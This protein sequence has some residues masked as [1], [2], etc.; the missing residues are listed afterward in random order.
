MNKRELIKHIEDLPYNEGLI[1]DTIKISR[2][3]LLKLIEQLDEP[4]KVKIPQVIA[5]YIKQKKDD[6]Y[7]LLGAMI[8]IRS[9]KN[10]EIDEWFE[11]DDN[12]E[13]FARAWLDGYELEEKRY[14]VTI[15]GIVSNFMVLKH[16][17]NEDT[18]YMS[19]KINYTY[20]K[21]Y[22]TMKEIED[23]GFGWVFDCEGIE[24]EEVT[25]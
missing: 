2:N 11:E 25:E 24:V 8:E 12:M 18:W 22:H 7:H 17:I 1:V 16:N 3:G 4:Q 19:N 10:K 21:A 6:D 14:L 15:K 5:E 9:H 13:L 23:A 20:L